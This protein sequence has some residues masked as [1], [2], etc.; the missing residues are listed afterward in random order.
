MKYVKGGN[1]MGR[2][3]KQGFWKKVAITVTTAVIIVSGV[4][5]ASKQ[6]SP[7]RGMIK[8]R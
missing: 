6:N 2:P 4:V 5:V 1:K 7:S 8:P 3:K